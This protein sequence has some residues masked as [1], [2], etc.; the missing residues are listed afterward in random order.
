[1]ERDERRI[2]GAPGDPMSCDACRPLILD[3]VEGALHAEAARQVE[4]HVAGC[5][6]CRM[7]LALAQ[8]IESA[9]S[10]QELRLPPADFTA[11][12]LSALPAARTAGGSFWSHVLAPMAYAV[13]IL[14]LLYGLSRAL[15]DLARV[16]GGGSAW[17]SMLPRILDLGWLA[18]S[19]APGRPEGFV[20]TAMGVAGDALASVTAMSE[21][22]QGLY[23]ANAPVIH[24]T[25]AALALLWVLY[26]ERREARE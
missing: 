1:M 21:Q 15:P 20:R 8:R 2:P 16:T 25:L 23:S 13:S 4:T 5:P 12:V 22:L 18:P 19:V 26:D 10:G 6:I 11:R 24:L 14:A 17:V 3:Y 9:L 7:E